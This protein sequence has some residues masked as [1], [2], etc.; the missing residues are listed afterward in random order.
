MP[1]TRTS[2]LFATEH[3]DFPT[4]AGKSEAGGGVPKG[5]NAAIGGIELCIGMTAMGL[6][7]VLNRPENRY[8]QIGCSVL[9]PA[10]EECFSNHR[11]DVLQG[12][13]RIELDG[14]AIAFI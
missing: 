10:D 7:A 6:I 8:R 1:G 9:L 12:G 5:R 4:R 14:A 3:A 13:F 2:D 11:L